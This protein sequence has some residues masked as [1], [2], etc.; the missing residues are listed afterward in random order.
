MNIRTVAFL[1]AI[2]L[3]VPRLDAQEQKSSPT[4]EPGKESKDED[5]ANKYAKTVA[6]FALGMIEIYANLV[7][8]GNEVWIG[9]AETQATSVLD[10][11]A[12]DAA[13]QAEGNDRLL[14]QMQQ[15]VE[16]GKTKDLPVR[17]AVSDLQSSLRKLGR[18][19]DRFS[20][21][22][23]KAAHPIGE[24]ARVR[25]AEAG[26]GKAIELDAIVESWEAG[27]FDE[28][29]EHM[30]KAQEYLNVMRKLVTCLQDSVK[31]KKAACDPKQFPMPEHTTSP[32]RKDGPQPN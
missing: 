10:K 26:N 6:N 15:S 13:E 14:A 32:R 21:E 3:F 22:V 24:D 8:K 27:R 7:K 17:K 31:D 2:S 4:N 20:Y 28:A 23:D 11:I 25:F 12:H 30:K 29:I 5:P 9:L 1:I 19:L 16:K 18:E